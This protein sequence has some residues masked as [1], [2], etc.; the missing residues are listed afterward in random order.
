MSPRPP[1]GHAITTAIVAAVFLGGGAYVGSL[2]KSTKDSINNDIKSG[3]L[4]DNTDS[5]FSRGKIE[6]I[7]ADVLFGVGA[8][9]A[10]TAV[11]GLLEHGPDSTGVAE[12]H[13]I[14]IAP[15]FGPDG[16][17]MATGLTVWGRF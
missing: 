8:L 10:A 3:V 6:A 14:S 5:R 16:T 15:S 17:G 11:Y 4:V 7:G 12:H 2:S 13:T 9:I 1:R